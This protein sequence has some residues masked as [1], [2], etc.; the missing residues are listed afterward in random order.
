FKISGAGT[1]DWVEQF[2][3]SH[4]W[5][6]SLAVK[7]DNHIIVSGIYSTAFDIQGSSLPHPGSPTVPNADAAF[8]AEFSENGD[9]IWLK[10]AT[11]GSNSKIVLG[12]D[13]NDA[14]FIGGNFFNEGFIVGDSTH[15]GPAGYIAKYDPSGNAQWSRQI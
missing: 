3:N 14:I 12:L 4:I 9:L 8:L 6:T 1:V 5:G 10:N 13:R 15:T 7:R 11:T 2:G